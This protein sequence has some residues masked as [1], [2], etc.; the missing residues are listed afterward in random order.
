[1]L[2]TADHIFCS[3][4]SKNQQPTKEAIVSRPTEVFEKSASKD[5]Y[6][7]YLDS[8][9]LSDY[10]RSDETEIENIEDVL[11]LRRGAL[12]GQDYYVRKSVCECGKTLTFYDFVTTAVSENGHSKSFLV[13]A[14]F[15]NKYGFQARRT[16]KCSS[17]GELHPKS[18]YTTP[19]YSCIE[20]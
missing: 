20:R 7:A 2:R 9:D 16:V 3:W 12:N 11:D 4:C 18:T 13:H 8:I 6:R 14:L 15:S 19:N 5:E 10:V 1:M 17:C